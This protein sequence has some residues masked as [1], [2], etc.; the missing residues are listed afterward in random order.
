MVIS[1]S[2]MPGS[3]ACAVAVSATD[4]AAAAKSLFMVPSRK[5]LVLPSKR[6][7]QT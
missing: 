7:D 6:P 4:S 2:V 1:L 5:I 3:A